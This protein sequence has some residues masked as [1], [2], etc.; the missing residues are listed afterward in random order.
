MRTVVIG[1]I[2]GCYNELQKLM[3]E[4]EENQA[5][6]KN[7]DRLVF[8]GDYIDRGNNS[9]KV[10]EYIRK[11]Q[12]ENKN[13][14][15]LRG[16]HEQMLIDYYNDKSE[17][18]LFNGCSETIKSYKNNKQ[19]FYDDMEW[20]KSLPLYFNDENFVYVH[21]GIS[22]SKPITEQNDW[23]LLW[24]RESFI[25]SAEHFDKRVI[26]GHT[27]SLM[28]AGDD[29][30]YYTYANNV[31]IDT[32]CVYG[33]KLTALIIENDEIQRFYQVQKECDDVNTAS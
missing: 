30:P 27:P 23:Y 18:W 1:D 6:N 11:L 19:Q 5:Y 8:L 24:V 16:N 10:I 26:F 33:G 22:A 7:T 17:N 4:L 13:V 31:G 29:K 3:I 32:G 15:A 9:Q 20:M 2:H 21:A 25:Y 28:I 14:I 12:K